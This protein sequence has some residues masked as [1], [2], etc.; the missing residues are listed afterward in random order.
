VE[1]EKGPARA[2]SVSEPTCFSRVP[3]YRRSDVAETPAPGAT[4]DTTSDVDTRRGNVAQGR[5]SG[6]ETTSNRERERERGG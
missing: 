1:V 5:P 3:A 2:R 4:L 6:C